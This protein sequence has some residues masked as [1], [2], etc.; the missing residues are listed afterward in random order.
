MFLKSMLFLNLQK[1]YLHSQFSSDY[2][3]SQNNVNTLH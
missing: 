1:H 2:L 3:R